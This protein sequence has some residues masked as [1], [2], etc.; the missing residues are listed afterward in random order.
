MSKKEIILF[1]LYITIYYVV[2]MWIYAT[3]TDTPIMD[4]LLNIFGLILYFLGWI[5]LLIIIA[6]LKINK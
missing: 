5:V 1:S 4:A 3:I 2:I 6:I